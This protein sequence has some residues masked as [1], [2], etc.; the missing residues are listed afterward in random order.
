M[1]A[2]TLILKLIVLIFPFIFKKDNVYDEKIKKVNG[3]LKKE[4]KKFKGLSDAE[5]SIKL[6][7]LFNDV[8]RILEL[9]EASGRDSLR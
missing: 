3:V 6:S 5:K 9:R 2:F 7:N 1:A 4:T 8:K